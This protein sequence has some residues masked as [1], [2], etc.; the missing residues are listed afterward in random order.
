[1]AGPWRGA[2]G[3]VVP[4]VR[5]GGAAPLR[6]ARR[7][8][9]AGRRGDVVPGVAAA[10]NVLPRGLRLL[11]PAFPP[12][13]GLFQHLQSCPE[14]CFTTVTGLCGH[15][16][17]CLPYPAYTLADVIM[18]KPPGTNLPISVRHCS[19]NLFNMTGENLRGHN[20]TCK[21]EIPGLMG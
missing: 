10:R 17:L 20:I 1:M 5:G 18:L 19:G 16:C 4:P 9:A 11:L 2:D 21:S 6:A 15:A 8:A 3:A 12:P 14:A 7:G 13:L